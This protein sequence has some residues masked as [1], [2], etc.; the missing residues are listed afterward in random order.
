MKE[1]FFIP[2]IKRLTSSLS[3][4][5]AR[6]FYKIRRKMLLYGEKSLI[7]ANCKIHG[8]SFR[9]TGSKKEKDGNSK[10]VVSMMT[11]EGKP[12]HDKTASVRV[13]A[14]SKDDE[15]VLKVA[16]KIIVGHRELVLE[17]LKAGLLPE[18]TPPLLPQLE[19]KAEAETLR[20]VEKIA[21]G[22]DEKKTLRSALNR[23]FNEMV[24]NKIW[25]ENPASKAL[26]VKRSTKEKADRSL[27]QRA[28][29][30]EEVRWLTQVCLEKMESDARYAAVLLQ[31]ATGIST[32]EACALNINDILHYKDIIFVEIRAKSK[33]K[34]WESATW[35]PYDR[36]SGRVRRVACTPLAQVA[37]RVLLK[38][39][40]EA[41]AGAGASLIVDENG[42]RM[43]VLAYRAFVKKVLEKVMPEYAEMTKTDLLRTTFE[44]H[45]RT[46]CGMTADCVRRLMGLK[47]EQTYEAWYADYSAHIAL[48]A[49]EAQ[50]RR[51]Q[52]YIMKGDGE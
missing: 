7:L 47:A 34:R 48:L 10:R 27:R 25:K 5:F 12:L 2:E 14:G 44:V 13:R 35:E 20:V 18:A 46:L 51:G 11:P 50:L 22:Y 4:F 36:E 26:A 16:E 30:L 23:L 29:S 17:W 32:G 39:R 15:K 6:K 38:L 21:D 24:Y 40:L 45:C 8:V 19:E 3:A 33:Q 1:P 28:L 49:L 43:E 52:E 31:L 42:K 9:I 37:M 41:G